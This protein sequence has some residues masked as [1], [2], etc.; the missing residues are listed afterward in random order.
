MGPRFG[1]RLRERDSLLSDLAF[2]FFVWT[3]KLCMTCEWGKVT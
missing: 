2:S 1:I 3:E